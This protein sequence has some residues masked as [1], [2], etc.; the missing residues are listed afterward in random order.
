M[1]LKIEKANFIEIS[2]DKISEALQSGLAKNYK[3]V[4]VSVED[5]PNLREWGCP[6]EGISGN[7]RIIDVGGEPYMHDTKSYWVLNLIMRKLQ[8]K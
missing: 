5:C 1:Q 7:E 3:D 2:L 4:K 6:A 8:K